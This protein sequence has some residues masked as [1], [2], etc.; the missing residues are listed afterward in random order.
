MVGLRRQF[1]DHKS[2]WL[3]SLRSDGSCGVVFLVVRGAE[4]RYN[5]LSLD[6]CRIE[7]IS[8]TRAWGIPAILELL[9]MKGHPL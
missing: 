4:S 3:L 6:L 2:L 8:D 9:E 5:M 7:P 1:K